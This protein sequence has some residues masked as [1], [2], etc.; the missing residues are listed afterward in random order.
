MAEHCWHRIGHNTGPD[1]VEICCFC[2][3]TYNPNLCSIPSLHG[4][5]TPHLDQQRP[6]KPS[7]PCRD[8]MNCVNE[9]H[10][11]TR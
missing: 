11:S 8:R 5:F 9:D 1:A 7:G 4:K 6:A 3:T 2:G 10:D